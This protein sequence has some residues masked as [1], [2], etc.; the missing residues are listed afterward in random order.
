MNDAL[1]SIKNQGDY[2]EVA[3]GSTD[4]TI[5]I[6]KDTTEAVLQSDYF[7]RLKTDCKTLK[8]QNTKLIKENSDLKADNSGLGTSL[9]NYKDKYS[10]K[11]VV[12]ALLNVLSAICIAAGVN[13]LTSS[14]PNPL[15]TTILSIGIVLNLLTIPVLYLLSK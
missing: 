14:P 7:T 3:S 12:C 1:G 4:T 6:V 5:K 10:A 15:G 9:I 8:T 13:L 2:E 11:N